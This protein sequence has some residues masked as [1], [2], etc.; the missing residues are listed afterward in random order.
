MGRA[1]WEACSSNLGSCVSSKHLV[2]TE[3]TKKI[4]QKFIYS[5]TDALV[6][7]VLKRVLKFT[8]KQLGHVSVQLH[9][10]Q[11]AY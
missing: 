5:P 4:R 1:E 10:H 11:G 7:V 9:H 8:L 2:E 3:E 6:W